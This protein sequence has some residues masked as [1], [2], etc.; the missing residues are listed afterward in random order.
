MI[1]SQMLR[2]GAAGL[3]RYAAV[4][5]VNT[6]VGLALTMLLLNKAGCSYWTSAAAGT[7]A[8]VAVSYALNR[9]FTF[10]SRLPVAGTL[11]RFIVVAALC[12]AAA[13]SCSRPLGTALAGLLAGPVGASGEDEVALARNIAALLGCVFY[14]VLGYCGHRCWTF[15]SHYAQGGSEFPH[16]H[17]DPL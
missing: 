5:I 17:P 14:T 16:D 15:R 3:F 6:I 4:G 8:G 9:R 11:P 2:S 7:A 13:Y 12:Y 10:R 1:R